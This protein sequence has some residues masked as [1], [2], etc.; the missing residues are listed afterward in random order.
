[1][2]RR[3]VAIHQPNF[4]PW[5][6]WFDKLARADVMVLLDDVQFPKKGGAGSIVYGW[7]PGASRPGSRFQ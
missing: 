2:S 7:S 5:L 4:L 3:V 6:G 1:M